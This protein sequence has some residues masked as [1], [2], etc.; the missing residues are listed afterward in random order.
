MCITIVAQIESLHRS[1][2]ISNCL[3]PDVQILSIWG[4]RAE[5]QGT[6]E[7]HSH[8]TQTMKNPG[9]IKNKAKRAEVYAKY[10]EQKKKLK[11]KLRTLKEKE[12]EE[13]GEAA[14]PK[15]LPRTIENTRKYDETFVDDNDE[16]V[17]GDEK[18]DEFAKIFSNEVQPKIML[19]TRPKCSRKLYAVIKDI[20]MLIPNTFYYPRENYNVKEL[21]Q[22]A[23]NKKFTHVAVLGEKQKECNGILVTQ[24]P[25]GPTAYFKLTNFEPASKIP[26]HGSPTSHV[27]ELILNNF[28]TRLG[29]RVGR[30]LGA[31]FPHV[32]IMSIE[33]AEGSFLLAYWFCYFY[34]NL[35]WKDDKWSHSTTNATSSSYATIDISIARKRTKREHACKS[36]VQGLP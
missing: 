2:T 35:S 25:Y 7:G 8:R 21:V 14:A 33:N 32:R 27:P 1:I 28:S 19:T 18:D 30:F 34:R 29:R 4:G 6:I 31:L 12:A 36:W 11:K 17:L 26:G 23:S 9:Q 3:I 13:L 24:L 22:Y 15:Q 16:E 10:K 5:W 20:M